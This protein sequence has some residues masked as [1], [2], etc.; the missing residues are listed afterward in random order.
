M[1]A[2]SSAP[3]VA[4]D[5]VSAAAVPMLTAEDGQLYDDCNHNHDMPTMR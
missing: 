4:D 1:Y 2:V 5:L 3:V